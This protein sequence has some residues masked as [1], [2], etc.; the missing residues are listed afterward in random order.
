MALPITTLD[1]RQGEQW[2][3]VRQKG[4]REGG[5]E[6]GLTITFCTSALIK[7]FS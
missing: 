1:F 7:S 2:R 3:I 5:G 4:G 6:G